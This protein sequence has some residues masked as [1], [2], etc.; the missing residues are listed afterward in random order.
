MLYSYRRGAREVVPVEAAALA[1]LPPE[2]IWLDMVEPSEAETEAVEHWL[3][4]EMPTR[5][6]MREIEASS[7]VYEADDA[8]YLTATLLYLADNPPPLTTEVSFILK[9]H[10]LV[11][12]RFATPQ[13]FRTL[14]QRL[15]RLERH[16]TQQLSTAQGVLLWLIDAIIARLADVMERA[17]QD[18]DEL[19]M[20]IFGAARAEKAGER[21]DLLEAMARIGRNGATLS[22]VRESLH[23]LDR[24]LLAIGVTELLPPDCRKEARQRAKALS[25]DVQSL[26]DHVGFVSSKIDLLL[27]ATLGMI[28]IEQTN[29]IKIFSVLAMVFLPPTLIASIYGMNFDVMP[30]LHWAWGYPLALALMVLAAV[31]PYAYFKRKGWL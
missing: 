8:A 30:E 29:I 7:R 18:I 25:R 12:L 2:V 23:T 19:S 31:I 9:S 20:R 24:A 28:N 4:I 22:K 3:G 26:T 1:Q 16:A 13:P 5:E 27:E 15:E 11:S 14:R 21:P 17:Q 6:E 10:L